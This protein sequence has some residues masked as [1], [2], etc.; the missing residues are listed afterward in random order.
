[1]SIR[2]L[3]TLIAIDDHKT[4]TAAAEAVFISHAAVSQQM[5][6]LEEEWGV[7]LFDRSRRTPEL[8]P[9]GRE[10]VAKAREVVRA[11]DYIVPSTMGDHGFQGDIT[12]GAVPSTLTGLAP[13]AIMRMKERFHMLSVGLQPGLTATLVPDILRGAVDAAVISRPASLPADI[14]F[15]TLAEEP[16]EL[17]ASKSLQSDNPNVLLRTS[18]FIRFSRDAV[19]GAMVDAWLLREK[20][21]VREA[22]ELQS[23]EAIESMVYANLGV[24]ITPRLS[25]QPDHAP[26]IRRLPLG[27]DAPVRELG[28]AYHLQSPKKRLI[29]AVADALQDSIEAGTFRPLGAEA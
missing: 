15:I 11:Y 18:P 16:L 6:T 27:D 13:A 7:A 2:M 21:R 23:F 17:L 3:R 14:D 22:M 29:N 8:T 25:V 4:F 28:L 19:V 12:L 1:M 24:S 20:I 26:D 10:I 5:R 9:V